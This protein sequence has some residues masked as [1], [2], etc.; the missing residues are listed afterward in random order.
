MILERELREGKPSGG[1]P[2]FDCDSGRLNVTVVYTTVDGTLAAL[3]TAARLAKNLLAEITLVMVEEVYFRYPLDRSPVSPTFLQCLCVALIE[4]ANLDPGEVKVE[5]H[6]CRD[7]MKCL[8]VR[9]RE[10]SL[11][12][13]GAKRKGW[14]RPE[15]RLHAALARQGHDAILIREHSRLVESR[16]HFVIQSL[17][18]WSKY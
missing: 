2:A 17:M 11:V 4:S 15:R 13:I 1:G 18:D 7:R 14:A 10:K 3:E 12:M 16:H 5:I 9:L 8:Q 6:Y